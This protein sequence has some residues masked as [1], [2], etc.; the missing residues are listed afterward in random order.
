LGMSPS[1]A[2]HLRESEG[3]RCFDQVFIWRG[4]FRLFIAIIKYIEDRRNAD[5]D[6]RLAGVRA[7]IVIEN[8]TRFYS[9]YLPL[10]YT[11]LVR[12]NQIVMA[13]GVNTMER[14]WRTRA[15]PKILLAETF[16]EGWSL[17]ERYRAF[18][19]GVITDARFPRNGR[20]DPQAGL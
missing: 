18:V 15:R 3:G 1:E 6:M 17:F 19:L 7:I 12:Q 9:S 2:A 10:L 4:D 16:E 11:E 13:D 14:I 8:S 5:H 20:S